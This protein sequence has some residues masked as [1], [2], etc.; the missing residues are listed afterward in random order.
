MGAYVVQD[1]KFVA[2]WSHKLNETQLK[3]AVCD[4]DFLSIVMVL[5]EIYAILLDAKL[6]INTDPSELP[7]IISLLI[8]SFAE[9]TML[10]ST[11][12]VFTSFMAKTML[13][14][15]HFLTSINTKSLS[16]TRE[17]NFLSL[18]ILFPKVWISK[19]IL[20]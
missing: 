14:L 9:S 6:H 19:N 1:D 10:N 5:A 16:S 13:L 15:T 7:P 8:V 3:Y 4:K 11:I 20:S 18:K 2:F 12:H 17:T